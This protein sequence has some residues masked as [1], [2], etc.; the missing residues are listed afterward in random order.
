MKKWM[1]LILLGFLAM[2]SV[3]A[4]KAP[5]CLKVAK[6]DR[7][8]WLLVKSSQLERFYTNFE[9]GVA[10]GAM[11][12]AKSELSY[13]LL[14][15]EKDGKRVF[16]FELEQKGHRLFLNKDYPVQSCSEGSLLLETF[17]QQDGKIQGC[18][19]GKHTNIGG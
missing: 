6:S 1:V 19:I 10:F 4:Q 7:P 2:S 8:T 3:S 11:K 14:A 16:A 18:R 17:L 5:K 13:Y 15:Q 9:A 12:I